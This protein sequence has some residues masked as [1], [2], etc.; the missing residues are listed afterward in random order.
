MKMTTKLREWGHEVAEFGGKSGRW[1]FYHY[2]MYRGIGFPSP[3]SEPSG[4]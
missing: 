4:E 3:R 1:L 2:F